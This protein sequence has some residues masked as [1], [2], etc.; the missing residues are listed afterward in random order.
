VLL[1]VPGHLFMMFNTGLPAL[2]SSLISQDDGLLA[3][4][5]NQVW[6]PL[7]A[8][9][10][11]ASFTEAWAEG[12]R[13]YHQALADNN[14]GIIDLKQAW[15]QYQPVTLQKA[16]F[17]LPLPEPQRTRL[18]VGTA[19]NQLLGKSID[20]L[21]LPYQVMLTNNPQDIA[22]RMQI[23]ILY[24]RY[25]L[26]DEAQQAF[27]ALAELAPGNSAVHTNQGNLYLLQGLNDKAIESYRQAVKL[28]GGIRLNLS[29]AYYRQANLNAARQ[30]F[31]EAV[32]L[33]PAIQQTHA[34]YAKL[35][36]Q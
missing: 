25:G 13:K 32:R 2:E 20:R 10:V 5:G 29:M 35:L 17:T 16:A 33:S 26:Y 27:D 34:A 18:L 3:I 1:E 9:M 7:E 21:I 12:A 4:H 36:S 22:A 31:N 30:E 24:S 14:L 19:R 6:I 15:Q 28:D 8:T 11:H 23:A